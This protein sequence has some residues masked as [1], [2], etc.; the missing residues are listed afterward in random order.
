[1]APQLATTMD[2]NEIENYLR[3]TGVQQGLTTLLAEI[4]R[5]RPQEPI[6]FM[7]DYFA[8]LRRVARPGT[9]FVDEALLAQE[10]ARENK[11]RAAAM[12]TQYGSGLTA[13]E[14]AE[15]EGPDAE[16]AALKI[17]AVARGR[18]ARKDVAELRASGQLTLAE[19]EEADFIDIM[20]EGP[21]AEAAALKIQARARGRAA[22]R[23]VAAMRATG[24]LTREEAKVV[25]ALE[26]MPEGPEAEAAALKI[27]ARARG[28]AA[29]REV[30]AMRATGELTKEE[31]A[32]V[33]AVEEMPE[34]PRGRGGGAQDPGACARARCS[35][36]GSGASR[37]G[38]TH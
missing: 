8:R 1:M 5:S 11:K 37:S 23:E 34:G 9:A 35:Q 17:Q 3:R 16:A 19:E 32:A 6:D 27:Q 21:E 12:T 29:R 15:L 28:R 2:R 26:D 7:L 4:M 24:E 18:A 10:R 25:E 30:A 22:R 36:G 33:A 14:L 38:G 20:P 13:D 31:E